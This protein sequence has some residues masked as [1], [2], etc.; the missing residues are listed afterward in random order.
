MGLTCRHGLHG[1]TAAS[2]PAPATTP[3]ASQRGGLGQSTLDSGSP[4][5]GTPA[6][7]EPLSPLLFPS[8]HPSAD[9]S[10][11]GERGITVQHTPGKDRVSTMTTPR[12]SRLSRGA[13]LR[14]DAEATKV[15]LTC[16][17]ACVLMC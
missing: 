9:E 6:R 4:A 7:P 8:P 16:S 1:S 5:G 17:R 10:S 11:R 15:V 2:S 12:A 3:S 13:S 14:D